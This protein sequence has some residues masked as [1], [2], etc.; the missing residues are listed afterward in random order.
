[1]VKMVFGVGGHLDRGYRHGQ[2]CHDRQSHGP[3]DETH[4]ESPS[5]KAPSLASPLLSVENVVDPA[6]LDLIVVSPAGELAPGGYHQP[7]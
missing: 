6:R 2:Q 4:S 3:K 7:R 1:M 5:C